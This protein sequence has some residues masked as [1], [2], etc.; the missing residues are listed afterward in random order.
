MATKTKAGIVKGTSALV[1]KS[2]VVDQNGIAPSMT[3]PC[4]TVTINTGKETYNITPIVTSLSI[5]QNENEIAKKAT[6]KLFNTKHGNSWFTGIFNVR[7]SVYIYANI[8]DGPVEVFRGYIW[9]R[10]YSSKDEKI[11]TLVCYDRLIYFQESEDCKFF[12]A[13]KTTSA[14][15][16]SLCSDWGVT[17][18]FNYTSIT[19]PK[20]PLR[21]KLSD[22]FLTDILA[23]VKKSTGKEA[24]MYCDK[25][26]V[27]IDE[28]GQNKTIYKLRSKENV[29]N[30]QSSISMSGV[31]T[32][33]SIT[34]KTDD[35]ER[36]PIEAVV[37]GKTDKY[38]TIQRL[39]DKD[40][41]TT[42][43][44]AKKEAQEVID[45]EGEPQRTYTVK[46]IDIPFMKKGDR[47]D[48]SAGDMTEN[49][50]V[51]SISHDGKNKTMTV[52]MKYAP[53]LAKANT[54]ASPVSS[55][56][57]SNKAV[58]SN[59]V[60]KAGDALKLSNCPLYADSYTSKVSNRITGTY[61]LYDGVLKQN[62]YRITNKAANVGKKPIGSYVTGWIDASKA[63]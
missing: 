18:K 49:Y 1:K 60:K 13:G 42:L 43:A 31:V 33:I 37:K 7:D 16:S 23:E 40:E 28:F 20:L 50:F 57:P 45:E 8:G 51:T 25:G 4:Y 52:E 44:D 62:R 36:T 24:V 10:P 30:T 59:G 9:D 6:I 54:S 12:T 27:Y 55:I 15:C 5:D 2:T 47:V 56:S 3:N 35:D 14:V 39:H 26:T 63:K 21:G 61:Y 34:G 58:S 19:H 17:L 38:G 11:L 46:A 29:I 53:P 41:D 32:Q 48:V 22:I